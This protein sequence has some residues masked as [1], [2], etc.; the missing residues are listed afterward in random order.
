MITLEQSNFNR[1][2]DR[3]Q[4]MREARR[5]WNQEL[6]MRA[7]VDWAERD[8]PLIPLRSK[9]S[10]NETTLLEE[11]HRLVD[12][13]RLVELT[14]GQRDRLRVVEEELDDLDE[15]TPEAQWMA[16][17]MTETS[18]K[19]DEILEAVHNLIAQRTP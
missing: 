8:W 11:Y 2:P 1:D 13:D 7:L 4:R 16:V 10:A 14:P 3:A 17:K 18:N 6:S 15:T 12:M 19:L 9:R 5:R